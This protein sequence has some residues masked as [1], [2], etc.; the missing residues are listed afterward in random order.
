[1]VA[2]NDL[3]ALAHLKPKPAEPPAQEAAQA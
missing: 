2:Y 1:L 3:G